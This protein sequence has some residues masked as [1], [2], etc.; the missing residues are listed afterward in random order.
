[1][2]DYANGDGKHFDLLIIDDDIVLLADDEP[3][4][5]D[6]RPSIAQDVCHAI[7]ESLL[8]IPL[9]GERNPLLRR[10][11]HQQVEALVEEDVRIIPGTCRVTEKPSAPGKIWVQAKTYEYTDIA[12]Y[13]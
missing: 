13:L 9:V 8:L 7:R 4:T 3:R 5:V 1:M 10:G 2:M 6:G 12:F 11:I